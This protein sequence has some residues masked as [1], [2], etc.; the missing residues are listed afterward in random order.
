MKSDLR[1]KKKK[2]QNSNAMFTKNQ[3]YEPLVKLLTMNWARNA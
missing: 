1:L 2:Q 3:M